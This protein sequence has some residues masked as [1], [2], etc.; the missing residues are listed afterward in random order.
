MKTIKNLK[1]GYIILLTAILLNIVASGLN[2]STWY[3]FVDTILNQ[4]F[5]TVLNQRLASLI[6]LFVLYPLALGYG[7][8]VG[9][10]LT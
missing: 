9:K 8:F 10:K 2:L 6:F 4:G 5:S 7:A 3:G 1:I